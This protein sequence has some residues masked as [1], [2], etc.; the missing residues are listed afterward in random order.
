ME[1]SLNDIYSYQVVHYLVTCYQ[2]QIIRVKQYKDDIWLANANASMYPVIRISN[3]LE[4]ISMDEEYIRNVHRT[5]LNLIQREGELLS[6]ATNEE[7]EVN[8]SLFMKQIKVTPDGVNDKAILKVFSDLDHIVHRVDNTQQEFA[9]LT[10]SIEE[11]QMR[12]QKEALKR[13][14]RKLRPSATIL[15]IVCCV[16]Y[17]LIL[18]GFTFLFENRMAGWVALGAYYKM[19]VV[20]AHEYWRLLS[21]GFL[22]GD[23]IILAFHMYVLY[24]VG[25]L[26]EPI[27]QKKWYFAI[28]VISIFVGNLCMLIGESNVIGLGAGAGI[29]GVSGAFLASVINNKSYRHPLMKISLY[30]LCILDVLVCLLPGVSIMA[31]IGGLLCGFLLGIV[32]L[33]SDTWKDVRYHARNACFGF[34]AFLSFL[35]LQVQD[36]HSVNKEFDE[37]IV[38]IFIHTPMDGY[39]R[40]LQAC[41]NNVYEME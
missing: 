16:L 28:F 20:A 33:P 13:T 36:V 29:L 34:I 6:I 4:T 7:S 40:Y 25:R 5:I 10:R 2:Y 14:K 31:Q 9:N 1:L 35:G 18:F 27:F 8:D 39:A 38:A 30:K 21:S 17:G 26:C 19:N 24:Q 37:D 32:C 3:K 23:V 12:L 15:I 11:A 41:Y 22:Y